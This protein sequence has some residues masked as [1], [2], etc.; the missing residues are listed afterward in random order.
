MIIELWECP[1]CKQLYACDEYD[2][3]EW[4]DGDSIKDPFLNY[5]ED[6]YLEDMMMMDF[7]QSD[8]DDPFDIDEYLEDLY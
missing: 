1:T 4:C 7:N 2:D 3:C 8:F 6:D 5:F